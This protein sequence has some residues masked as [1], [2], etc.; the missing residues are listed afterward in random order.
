VPFA[1]RLLACSAGL[2]QYATATAVDGMRGT[3]NPYS[4][5]VLSCSSAYSS[6]YLSAYLSAYRSAWLPFHAPWMSSHTGQKEEG[7]LD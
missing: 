2:V 3:P 1:T 4:T 6:A 7:Q 5:R